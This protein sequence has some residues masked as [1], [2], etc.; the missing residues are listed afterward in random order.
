MRDAR[1]LG[2]DR[3]TIVRYERLVAE[4]EAVLR[5][6]CA[7]LGEAF[8]DEMLRFHERDEA[9]FDERERAWKGATASPVSIAS[10]DRWKQDLTARQIAGVERIAGSLMR[11]LGYEA[12]G[13]DRRAAWIAA[14]LRD[15]MWDRARK[16]GRSVRKRFGSDQSIS[17]RS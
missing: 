11:E 7:F 5:E 6:V 1:T 4:P 13:V 3:Y 8:S 16:I 2:A 17:E 14:D 9:G 10:I 15:R 12:S